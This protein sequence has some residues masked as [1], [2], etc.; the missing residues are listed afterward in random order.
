[1]IDLLWQRR[2]RLVTLFILLTVAAALA[3]SAVADASPHGTQADRLRAIEH[4]RLHA[5]V[6][7]DAAAAGQYIADDF[8]L[9]NPGGALASRDEYLSLIEG[10][11]IDYLR[12]EPASPIEVDVHGNAA[13]LRFQVHFDLVVGGEL[14]VTHEG[15]I[16]EIYELRDGRW[17]IVWEQA[18]AVPND[19]DLFIR[20]LLPK[21]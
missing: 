5:L 1:M 8:E 2:A 10:E 4:A 15:W 18:T 13:T 21:A 12:F 11:V 17:R 9:V 20:S 6:E 14:R 16:T 19:F 7:G 3:I